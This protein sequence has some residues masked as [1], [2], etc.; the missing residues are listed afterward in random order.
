MAAGI[1]FLSGCK[2]KLKEGEIYNKEFIPA[3]TETV[4]ISTVHTDGKMSY[5]TVMPYVYYYSD[6]YEIDIRDYNE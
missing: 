3:H 1:V 5:T 4:L 2:E 6:S